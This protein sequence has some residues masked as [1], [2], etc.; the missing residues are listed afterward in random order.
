[1]HLDPLQLL[2]PALDGFLSKGYIDS[3]VPALTQMAAPVYALLVEAGR[4][5]L[6]TLLRAWPPEQQAEMACTIRALAERF[7][8]DEFGKDLESSKIRTRAAAH[9]A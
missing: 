3:K 1:V 4:K 6:E 8:S 7:L 9:E 2:Q 5:Q